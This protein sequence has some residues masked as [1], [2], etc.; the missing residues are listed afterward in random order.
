MGWVR[1]RRIKDL[2]EKFE[3]SNDPEAFYTKYA[4]QVPLVR[5]WVEEA[6][7]GGRKADGPK[8]LK[9]YK[10]AQ[11][12]GRIDLGH[13]TASSQG[14]H[15]IIGI[16]FATGWHPSCNVFRPKLAKFYEERVKGAD[17]ELLWVSP[18]PDDKTKTKA[19]WS[20]YRK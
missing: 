16:Y 11:E 17:V 4:A 5:Q 12:E 14:D 3:A 8:M 10:E 18:H 20:R 9:R 19:A 6:R 15:N 13:Q 1:K 2:H 7:V